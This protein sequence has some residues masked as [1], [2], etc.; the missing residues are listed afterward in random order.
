VG[1]RSVPLSLPFPARVS[2]DRE[3]TCGRA[4]PP[5]KQKQVVE[6]ISDAVADVAPAVRKLTTRLPNLKDTEA[7]ARNM[8]RGR[9]RFTRDPHVRLE[10]RRG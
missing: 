8:E 7:D 10:A 3:G 5:R 6:R 9:Q 1:W 4:I 2:R